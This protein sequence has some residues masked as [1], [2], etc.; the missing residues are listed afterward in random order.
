LEIRFRP[1]TLFTDRYPFLN[2]FKGLT[3]QHKLIDYLIGTIGRCYNK[4]RQTVG[5]IPATTH[6]P[7]NQAL[8]M[9]HE[10]FMAANKELEAWSLL[11]HRYVR[12][13]LDLSLQAVSRLVGQSIRNL[14]RRQSL[15]LTRLLSHMARQQ[16]RFGRRQHKEILRTALPCAIPPHLVGRD[17]ILRRATTQLVAGPMRHLLIYGLPGIGKSSFACTLAHCLIDEVDL[18]HVIW[19]DHCDAGH[20]VEQIA[21]GLSV[22]SS[23]ASSLPAADDTW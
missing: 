4:L 13:D 20:L 5:F 2:T 22:P 7:R 12:I 8:A 23:A 11:Y 18:D 10:D 6:E 1:D 19:L 14:N 17:P 15:G 16:V 21:Q 3:E 9:L